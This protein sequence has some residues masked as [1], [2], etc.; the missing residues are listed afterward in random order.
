M[1]KEE[2]E[3]DLKNIEYEPVSVGFQTP[4][5]TGFLLGLGIALAAFT[6][7]LFGTVVVAGAMMAFQLFIK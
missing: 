1:K 4:I 6:F 5:K 3:L 7:Q 2:L